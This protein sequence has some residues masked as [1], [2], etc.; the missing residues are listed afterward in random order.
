MEKFTVKEN[1][2]RLLKDEI[3]VFGSNLKGIHGKGAAKIAYLKFGA[4]LGKNEGLYGNTYA[5]PTKDKYLKPLSLDM[6]QLKILYFFN[7]C[8]LNKNKTFL[9]TRIG[10]GLAGYKDSEIAPLFSKSPD[11]V[12][13]PEIWKLY[14]KENPFISDFLKYKIEGE[15]YGNN[16]H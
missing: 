1:I 10:C 6:I 16:R 4:K 2:S 15:K 12:R 8:L 5:I 14:L 9:V 3:F 11:N 13:L 7:C